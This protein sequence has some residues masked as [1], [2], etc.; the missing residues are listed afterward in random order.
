MNI[1]FVLP[2]A[3]LSGGVHATAVLAS[4]LKQRGHDVLAVCPEYSPPSLRARFDG[5]LKGKGWMHYAKQKPSHFDDVD[6]PLKV[7]SHP[8]P[9]VETDVPDADVIVATWWETA[10]WIAKFSDRK[11]VKTYTVRHHEVH[12]YLPKARTSATYSLPFHK[13]AVSKWLLDIMK[14]EYGDR[15][16]SLVPD[17]V[18]CQKYCA[19][20]RGKQSVPTVGMMYSP[21]HW[22]GCDISLQAF[23]LAARNI[24]NLRLK[25]FGQR[26]PATKNVELPPNTQFIQSPPQD[27]IKDIYASC[28]MWLFGSR[29]EGFGLP[30]LESM[31]C[32][33]PV[34]G[35]PA[36]AAPELLPPGGGILVP[37]ENPEEMARAI[38]RMCHLSEAEW[39][40]MSDAAYATAREYSWTDAA[41]LC[42]QAFY[43]AIERFQRGELKQQS[44]NLAI[45]PIAKHSTLARE[46]L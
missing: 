23:R 15:Y 5:L 46:T 21:K 8:G 33:T 34:V 12:D 32:R 16:V 3:N 2:P 42:E 43:T 26:H 14:N 1:T 13:I 27:T 40:S 39:K 31:A 6:V 7:T 29:T 41:R 18:N 37:P 30:I 20:P 44:P 24:P 9:I 45:P 19:P 36:G 10:E 22:K 35:T 28:D 4:H 25:I 17:S 11:G 38:E